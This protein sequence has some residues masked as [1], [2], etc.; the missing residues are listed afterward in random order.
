MQEI[1]QKYFYQIS[2]ALET[3]P[4]ELAL[5]FKTRDQLQALDRRLGLGVPIQD[6]QISLYCLRALERAELSK[7]T[8][9]WKKVQ[10]FTTYRWRRWVIQVSF[11]LAE[12][13][14][15]IN[16]ESSPTLTQVA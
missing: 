6:R 14:K 8:S 1:F 4:R 11:W 15:L 10:V 9:T 2:Q 13:F 5:I 3:M 16:F 7:A 12:F